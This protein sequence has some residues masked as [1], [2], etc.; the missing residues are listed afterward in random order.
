MLVLWS[1]YLYID[2]Q[3]HCMLHYTRLALGNG[4]YE[5][6]KCR[7][8]L[9]LYS[10]VCSC[11]TRVASPS[12]FPVAG[13]GWCSPSSDPGKKYWEHVSGYWA[14][15]DDVEFCRTAWYDGHRVIEGLSTT[16]TSE[17]S[18]ARHSFS[19]VLVP[20]QMPPPSSFCINLHVLL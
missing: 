5:R 17:Y 6:C 12:L 13:G 2:V 8:K 16:V 1:L 9:Y 14:R 3:I 20:S 7:V 10:R 4:Y 15:V 19:Q 18:H 11:L